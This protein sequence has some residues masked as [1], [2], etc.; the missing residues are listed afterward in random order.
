MAKIGAE[1]RGV[2]ISVR[3]GLDRIGRRG[4]MAA[5]AYLTTSLVALGVLY[6][7]NRQGDPELLR[8][9]LAIHFIA[10]LAAGL[11]PATAKAAA[12]NGALATGPAP[13]ARTIV[14]ASGVKA[15]FASPALALV[16]RLADPGIDARL[17]L[18]T[19]LIA[20][21]G[22]AASDL[23]V[24]H[25]L[26]GRHASAI[27]IKQGSLGGGLLILAVL[28]AAGAPLPVALGAAT[29]ARLA[30]IGA[31]VPRRRTAPSGIRAVGVGSLLRDPRW[32]SLAGASV[33]AAVGG[34][35]DRV[36]GLRYLS[37]DDWAG[38]FALYEVFSKFWFIPYVI[39]PILFARTAAGLDAR[40]VGRWGMLATAAAGTVFA[41]G[42]AVVLAAAP[43][44]PRT[45]LGGRLS[46]HTPDL[47]IVAF[48]VAVALNSLAQIRIAEIQ[49]RGSAH[50]ALLIMG[51]GALAA[52]ALFYFAARSY[53]APGLLYAWL[54]K[55]VIELLLAYAPLSPRVAHQGGGWAGSRDA[56]M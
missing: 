52:V 37:A 33:I 19:P 35:A 41:I 43:D 2:A 22:F 24:L 14:V 47:A 4:A 50:G 12:L 15:L 29:L 54:V 1:T 17:L 23:R 38:Y 46:A 21:A 18:W 48:A 27:W 55:A 51:G 36:F 30:L 44:L 34:S 8:Q 49:G 6:V 31:I 40:R 45:L 7:L 3:P 26:R 16:W 25:D 56:D 13:S 42:V 5:A 39:S 11:E 53:G 28:A 9:V 20:I 10:S 32:F